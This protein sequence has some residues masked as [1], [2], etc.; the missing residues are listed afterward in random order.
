MRRRL[1][2]A[3]FHTDSCL[4][5]YTRVRMEFRRFGKIKKRERRTAGKSGF[6]RI[7][8][9]RAVV[10]LTINK[11][12]RLH[13]TSTRPCDFLPGHGR[14]RVQCGKYPAAQAGRLA[15]PEKHAQKS[16]TITL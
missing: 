3:W 12:R 6:V 7:G 13:T 1:I 4:S 16:I 9:I 2:F 8:M 10:I 11:G 5:L 14:Q 15:V